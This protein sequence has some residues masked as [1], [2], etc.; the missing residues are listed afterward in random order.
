MTSAGTITEQTAEALTLACRGQRT[1]ADPME[2]SMNSRFLTN[3]VLSV[4]GAFTVVASMVW[5]PSTFMW[6]MFGAGVLSVALAGGI[7]I[8]G[9]GNAQR[10]LDG[11]IGILGAWTIVASLVF[12][13]SVVTWLGFATGAALVGLALIGLTLHELYTERVVHSFEVHNPVQESEFASING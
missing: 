5:I 9:R 4:L 11:T 12:S 1:A 10:A 13:G 2:V 3:S 6:L 7:A 8:R